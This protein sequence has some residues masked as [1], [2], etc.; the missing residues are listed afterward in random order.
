MLVFQSP[1]LLPTIF[2]IL[3]SVSLLSGLFLLIPKVPLNFV[4]IHTAILTL[5]LL[6]ALTA[7]IFHN[8][9]V[10]FGP[11]H[12]DALSWL[13]ALFVLTISFIVQRYSVHYLLGEHSYRK[14]FALLTITTIADSL[15]WLSN[16]LRLLLLFWGVT[17]LGLT[18]L[19][20]LKKEWQVARNTS[21]VSG[22]LFAFSWII[23]LTAVIWITHETGHWELSQVLSTNSL[24][25]LDSWEKTCINLLLIA[26]VVIPAAQWPFQ[27]WL[28]DSA[29]SPTPISAVM[30]AGIVNAGGILLTRFAPIFSGDAAQVVLLILSSFSV[31]MG[32]GIMLIQVDYK[33][34]LVGSTIAQMG[35]MLI[36]CAL[37]AYWAAI[38]HAMLHGL[39]KATLFLQAGSAVHH[40]KSTIRTPQPSSL[41]W[42][43]IGAIVALLMGGGFWLTSPKDGYQLISALILG[44]SVLLAW[45]QLV[46][47]GNG[48]LGRIAG[49][50]L[51]AGAGI[52]FNLVHTAFYH[53]LDKTVQIGKESPAPATIILLFILLA[54][55]AL[56]LLF[57]RY[58]SSTFFTVIYLWLLRLS[59]PKNN[60]FESHPK[61]LTRLLSQGG[62]VR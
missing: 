59:E 24:K 46:A 45:R 10:N 31:L 38:I 7:L 47:N 2:L 16:D 44:W 37:G 36:Q 58:R 49:L 11:W 28:L 52:V 40:H 19:I 54:G 8:G 53:M 29:I 9:S 27:R 18:I 3:L 32:T 22:R 5:P 25:E 1:N 26:A 60:F 17:L 51:F 23:L 41:I 13:L 62:N 6:A 20:G 61:Y 14:Y 43:I 56:G 35:F 42:T 33:R 50:I 55:S 39:F 57:N 15:A 30:H 48:S 21:V 4:R 12:L 34:Q